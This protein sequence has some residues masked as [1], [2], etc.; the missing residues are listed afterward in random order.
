MYPYRTV[1][2]VLLTLAVGCSEK[3]KMPQ[4]TETKS[5]HGGM[6]DKQ[7]SERKGDHSGHSSNSAMLMVT[8]EPAEVRAGSPV[9]LKLMIHGANG[10]MV[11]S[12]ETIHEKQVHLI[13]VREGLD[14]F[15][16]VH[17]ELDAAGNMMVTYTF[18]K[19][20]RYF[21]F[22]DHKPAGEDQ[23]VAT[24]ELEVVGESPAAPALIPNAPGKVEGD[25]LNAKIA[26]AG[27]KADEE[28]R[29]TFELLDKTSGR[30]VT[31]LQP[32]LG[33]MGH[34][35]I[36]S[37]DGRRYV[38]AHAET[39]SANGGSVVF[40]AHFMQPGTFKGWGQFQRDGQVRTVPFVIAVK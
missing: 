26:V 33:A 35:V 15:G 23:A 28:T 40:A 37:A 13:L 29:I 18:P 24:A 5:E 27:A 36:L 11:K 14:E 3:S 22:A 7:S 8:T 4:G 6:H 10:S 31:N 21:L 38:H 2:A 16:H 1:L 12:F 9:N 20:G 19:G 34:L 25:A 39:E 17:P 32:Y 30:Q